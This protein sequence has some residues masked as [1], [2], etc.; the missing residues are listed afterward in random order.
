MVITMKE[1]KKRETRRRENNWTAT[2]AK[3]VKNFIGF[4]TASIQTVMA[5]INYV[6]G[7]LDIGAMPL[8]PNTLMISHK[9]SGSRTD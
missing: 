8:P 2:R 1:S 3:C 9:N 6:M 4:S 7:V 5:R